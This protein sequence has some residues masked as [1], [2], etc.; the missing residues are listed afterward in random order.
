MEYEK[1]KKIS[2]FSQN[3]IVNRRLYAKTNKNSGARS[4]FDKYAVEII[5]RAKDG[6]SNKDRIAGMIAE[7]TYWEWFNEGIKD[8]ES[9]IDTQYSEFSRNVLKADYE[10]RE[11]LRIYIKNYAAT[12]YKAAVWLLERSDPDTYKLRDKLEVKQEVEISQKAILEIPDNG[13]RKL[14]IK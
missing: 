2:K 14:D 7:C 8:I 6:A 1:P 11:K 12:D 5:R 10:Y 9:N 3:T 13:R 4:K